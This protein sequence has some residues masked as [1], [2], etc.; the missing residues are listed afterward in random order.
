MA[1]SKLKVEYRPRLYL[2][3]YVYK[4]KFKMLDAFWTRSAKT[5]QDVLEHINRYKQYHAPNR[6]YN[7]AELKKYVEW[8]NNNK[9]NIGVRIEGNSVSIFANDIDWL[10]KEL[11]A[12]VPDAKF[13]RVQMYEDNTLYFLK[14]PKFKY[15]VYFK[16]GSAP[17]DFLQ[18]VSHFI[19]Q[20]KDNK[21]VKV[22]N[23]LV[24]GAKTGG[25]KY[26]FS[27][28]HSSYHIDYVDEAM[29]TIIH[30]L[31]PNLVGKVYKLEKRPKK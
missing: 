31:F 11:A 14:E 3:K 13:Y 16:S 17:K 15:R 5:Y 21:K 22:C 23:S 6:N 19:E 24:I 29:L 27:Y 18:S 26:R 28:L 12:L 9:D 25:P 4:A 8:R 30:M 10:E 7:L 20:Y 2:K 1:L